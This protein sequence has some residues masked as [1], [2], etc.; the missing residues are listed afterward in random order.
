M[1]LLPQLTQSQV[2]LTK[3]VQVLDERGRVSTISIPAERPLTV[4]L[5]KREL[6]TLM[7]MGGNPEA[8]VLG[9]L[10]NQRLVRRIDELASVQVDWEVGAAAVTSHHGIAQIEE[11]TAKRV[12]TTGCGQGTVFGDLMDEVD[13]IHL[14]VDARLSQS[15][16]YRIVDTIRVHPSIYKKAGSVHGC[17]LFSAQG[18]LL[19]FVED[20][21]RHNA[22]DAIAGKMWLDGMAGGDK[23]FYTTGRLTS[24]MV[25]KG[26]QM[27]IPIL[28]SRSGTTEMGH[29]VA[30]QVGMS[31]FSRCTGRH[32]LL[33]T[34]PQR[35]VFQ[36]DFAEPANE[37][38]LVKA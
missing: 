24:E 16:L 1:P 32:F 6:V 29:R 5:D 22:V 27:G 33:L 3:E 8:L 36:L 35:L 19:Y 13:Q 31:L 11:R 9:Y 34:H 18:D 15:A 20:V 7:T 37:A 4:Y 38:Q 10:R 17:A 28:L 26:A 14:P 12:V 23:V 30:E 25:I 2:A 21:G